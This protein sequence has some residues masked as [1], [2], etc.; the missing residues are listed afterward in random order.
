VSAVHEC[1]RLIHFE[2]FLR[3]WDARRS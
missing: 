3:P 1:D 2:V